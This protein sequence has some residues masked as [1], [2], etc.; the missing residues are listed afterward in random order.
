MTWENSPNHELTLHLAEP[1]ILFATDAAPEV[2]LEDARFSPSD[3]SPDAYRRRAVSGKLLPAL[4][5][6]LFA[7]ARIIVYPNNA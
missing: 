1:L 7:T 5:D 4:M 6:G 3:P 2:R